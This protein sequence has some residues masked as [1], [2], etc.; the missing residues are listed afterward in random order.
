MPRLGFEDFTDKELSR[1]YV[2]DR[3]AEAKSVESTLAEHDI[4]YAVEVEPFRKIL[5]G[6]MPFENAGA[7]FYVLSGQAS[8]ARSALSAVGLEAGLQDDESD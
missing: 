3:L 8:F 2:A 4:D 1:I 7:A 6:V 5:L